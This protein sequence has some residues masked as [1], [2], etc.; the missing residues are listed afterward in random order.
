MRKYFGPRKYSVNEI[1]RMRRAIGL[2]YPMD[3]SYVQADRDADIESRLRTYM[4]NGT[5]PEE[6]EEFS[7]RRQRAEY[8]VWLERQ[9]GA[10]MAEKEEAK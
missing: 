5:D 9:R 7:N 2:S 4:Q 6:L 1:D 10:L 8:F 3:G